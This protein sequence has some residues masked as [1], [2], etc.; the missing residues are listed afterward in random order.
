V[1]LQ[2]LPGNRIVSA[3]GD[4]SLHFHYLD[5]ASLTPTLRRSWEGLHRAG[6]DRPCE[7]T[8]VA[9][10]ADD[11]EHV[12]TAGEDGVVNYFRLDMMEVRSPDDFGRYNVEW[13]TSA[14]G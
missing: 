8:A 6:P 9:T 12:A 14:D 5:E 13:S 11:G 4:G 7:C 3:T 10:S 1:L 2:A